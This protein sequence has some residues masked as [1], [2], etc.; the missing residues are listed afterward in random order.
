MTSID[1]P[2]PAKPTSAEQFW[3]EWSAGQLALP[4]K[5]CAA[6]QAYKA[7]YLWCAY[8]GVDYPCT[9]PQWLVQV[10]R[11]S[12][13]Q[14]KPVSTRVVKVDELNDGVGKPKRMFMVNEPD[15]DKTLE[16]WATE[17]VA[18]FEGLL[19]NYRDSLRG[20]KA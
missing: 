2:P 14:G 5:T 17:T 1:N 11:Y 3:N 7:Y 9:D 18:H 10:V 13:M 6:S 16:K 20:G 4:Y 8:K 12:A 15:G 19:R